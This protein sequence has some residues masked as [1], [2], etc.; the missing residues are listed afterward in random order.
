LQNAIAFIAQLPGPQKGI[1]DFAA[2]GGDV[3]AVISAARNI[4]EIQ[5]QFFLWLA[6]KTRKKLGR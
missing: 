4:D 6:R 2:V 3:D 5:K 1:D